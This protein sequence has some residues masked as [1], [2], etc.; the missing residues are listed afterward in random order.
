MSDDRKPYD[1]D[2]A[3]A[4]VEHFH[5]H[6]YNFR[7]QVYAPAR[8]VGGIEYPE[9]RYEVTGHLCGA[10]GPPCV[11]CG[12][13]SEALCDFPL[14]DGS[15]TCDR[16]LCFRCAPTIGA[17][18][19]YCAEHSE[20]HG[21]LL[22]QRPARPDELA[23]QMDAGRALDRKLRKRPRLPKAPP[24][25]RRWRVFASHDGGP[26]QISGWITELE[27]RRIASENA[28]RFVESWDDFVT[29]HRRTYPLAP[30][31]RRPR[32]T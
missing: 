13:V 31:R 26:R 17:D 22:F 4:D 14:A 5:H 28:T 32:P 11:Q 16:P 10:L 12:D 21:L 7:S 24:A 15:R 18:K 8:V 27:A 1:P 29:W 2:A 23:A 9:I 25:E 30:R 19:N 20:G 6:H 3:V